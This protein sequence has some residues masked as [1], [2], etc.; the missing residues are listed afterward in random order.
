MSDAQTG[1]LDPLNTIWSL[2]LVGPPFGGVMYE[3]AG[4]EAPFLILSSLALLD[5]GECGSGNETDITGCHHSKQQLLCCC[6]PCL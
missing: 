1:T 2:C 6:T 5:G 4:K 3:F